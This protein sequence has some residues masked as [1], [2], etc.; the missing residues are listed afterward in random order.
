MT[1]RSSED[2]N[3]RA[4]PDLVAFSNMSSE[5]TIPSKDTRVSVDTAPV[6]TPPNDNRSPSAAFR[7]LV[8]A[9]KTKLGND[10]A[11]EAKET[12]EG[13]KLGDGNIDSS[14]R[15][16]V[17]A[18]DDP[19]ISFQSTASGAAEAFL[20]DKKDGIDVNCRDKSKTSTKFSEFETRPSSD[21]LGDVKSFP[22]VPQNSLDGTIPP[23]S[24]AALTFEDLWCVEQ[25]LL[26]VQISVDIATAE[27][28]IEEPGVLTPI[29][30]SI[31]TA[32]SEELDSKERQEG[33][34]S[35]IATRG[36][37]NSGLESRVHDSDFGEPSSELAADSS[38]ENSGPVYRNF[39]PYVHVLEYVEDVHGFE[40]SHRTRHRSLALLRRS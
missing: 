27:T 5:E 23:C 8:T 2:S 24:D 39:G 6:A 28:T 38:F 34:E 4:Q 31:R 32:P 1:A 25:M 26:K 13:A 17:L 16:V 36:H 12:K 40:P 9:V 10:N 30:R 19:K 20:D 33:T 18:G 14:T 22:L 37:E 15:A 35:E 3:A 7:N 11:E 29:A 21:F